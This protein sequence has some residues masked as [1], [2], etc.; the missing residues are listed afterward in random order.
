MAG[1]VNKPL[2]IFRRPESPKPLHNRWG[3]VDISVPTDGSWNQYD[4]PHRPPPERQSYGPG[5][6]PDCSP[7]ER[8]HGTAGSNATRESVLR[9]GDADEDNK[10]TATN[11]TSIMSLSRQNSLSL[12][13]LRPSRLSVR[14]ASRPK[15]LRGESSLDRASH[16]VEHKKAEFAYKPIHQDYP[17]EISDKGERSTHRYRYIPTNGRYLEDIPSP[18]SPRSQSAT[19]FRGLHT[20]RDSFSESPENQERERGRD[21][22]RLNSRLSYYPDD[23]RQSVRSSI[24]G[25]SDSSGSGSG[26]RMSF[27][28]PPRRR[29][30]PFVAADRKRSSSLRPMTLAMVPDPEDLYE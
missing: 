13:G 23:D 27:A 18:R 24:A 7:S 15:H 6:V 5:F 8:V 11:R 4:N 14:L 21:Q 28:L 25:S 16:D 20:R 29:T 30:S 10:S 22:T 2:S 9:S 19:S 17:A 26:S 12:G 3:D 1:I